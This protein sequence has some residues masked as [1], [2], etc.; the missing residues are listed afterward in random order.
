MVEEV[1]GVVE[2]E[3]EEEGEGEGDKEEEDMGRGIR[4]KRTWGGG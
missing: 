2:E 4:R 1:E 3:Q